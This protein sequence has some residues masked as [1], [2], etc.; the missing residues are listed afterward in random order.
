MFDREG[1]MEHVGEKSGSSYASSLARIEKMYSVDIDA[2]HAKD[3][4]EA[5]FGRIESDKQRT[6]LD[7]R[8]LKRRSDAAKHG[9]AGG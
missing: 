2:E 1:F 9:T 7:P 3:K 6:D 8:K 4:R 5:F